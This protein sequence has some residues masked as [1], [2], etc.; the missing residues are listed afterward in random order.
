MAGGALPG[1]GAIA[2]ERV[3]LHRHL[4]L[5]AGCHDLV[6]NDLDGKHPGREDGRGEDPA[7]DDVVPGPLPMRLR[8][9]VVGHDG[10]AARED[11]EEADLR[12]AVPAVRGLA[13]RSLR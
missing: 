4:L 6:R 1:R 12:R 7:V 8:Q 2:A 9:R 10:R 11:K 3:G 5:E 13:R